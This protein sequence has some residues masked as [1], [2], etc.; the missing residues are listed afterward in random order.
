LSGTSGAIG[1][2]QA[3]KAKRLERHA[4]RREADAEVAGRVNKPAAPGREW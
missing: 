2:H 1:L 3:I 4:K